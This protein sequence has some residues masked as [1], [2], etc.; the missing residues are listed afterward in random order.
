MRV[1]KYIHFWQAINNNVYCSISFSLMC[2]CGAAD[3]VLA[4][5]WA[6]GLNLSGQNKRARACRLV[7][8]AAIVCC[9]IKWRKKVNAMKQIEITLSSRSRALAGISLSQPYI[10]ANTQHSLARTNA[11]SSR[12][13]FIAAAPCIEV[14]IVYALELFISRTKAKLTV[15][16]NFLVTVAVF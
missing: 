7:L 6:S 16:M 14:I 3:C 11:V 9:Q 2:V 1:V 8:S 5:W 10:I 13:P 4:R 12:S 15:I